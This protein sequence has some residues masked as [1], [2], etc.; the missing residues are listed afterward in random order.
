MATIITNIPSVAFPWEADSFRISS[1]SDTVL[2]LELASETVLEATLTPTASGYVD[3]HGIAQVLLDAM[4]TPFAEPLMLNIYLDGAA[5]AS[6]GILY[7][8]TLGSVPALQL[9]SRSF[10]TAAS[11]G[12]KTT[13]AGATETIS[14]YAT[15]ASETGEESVEVFAVWINPSTR[16]VQTTE[17]AI[18]CTGD[19]SLDTA[20]V[21]PSRITPPDTTGTWEL[22]AYTVSLGQRRITYS[23]AADG[24][25][26]ADTLSVKFYNT[27]GQLDTFH[28]LGQTETELK[29]TYNAATIG[30]SY[31]NYRIDVQPTLTASTGALSDADA[32]LFADLVA[33]TDIWRASDGVQLALT[34]CSSKPSTAWGA[35]PSGT[36]TFRESLTG[37]RL[38]PS[39]PADTFDTTFDKTYK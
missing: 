17:Q 9:A 10:L 11:G 19:G 8:R 21:S 3:V 32:K 7:S 35:S 23:I 18:K 34:D 22:S 13:V 2:K 31:R 33:S 16:A 38:E 4:D 28:F 29:P 26:N 5:D 25:T 15:D 12:T 39:M 30:G 24:R 37:Q 1:D 14:W 20:D 6:A 27:F 36:A